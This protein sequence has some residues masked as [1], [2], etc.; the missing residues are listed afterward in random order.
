MLYS[1]TSAQKGRCQDQQPPQ[2]PS[3]PKRQCYINTTQSAGRQPGQ[4]QP[5]KDER[6]GQRRIQR[7]VDVNG[8]D[9]IEKRRKASGREHHRLSWTGRARHLNSFSLLPYWHYLTAYLTFSNYPTLQQY[10]V[11]GVLC[12][13][14][15]SSQHYR[16]ENGEDRGQTRRAFRGKADAL[17]RQ[18]S[19]MAQGDCDCPLLARCYAKDG[20]CCTIST[21]LG[22]SRPA[23]GSAEGGVEEEPV[24]IASSIQFS[25]AKRWWRKQTV[26]VVLYMHTLRD[27]FC[28]V[29]SD[30]RL[31][32]HQ[33]ATGKEG[34]SMLYSMRY[35]VTR[36][37]K[38]S[39]M[40][41]LQ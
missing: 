2:E 26:F 6:E 23:D 11:R 38:R 14:A 13:A 16:T 9:G 18:E 31:P 39:P 37:S 1:R 41:Q 19:P 4:D 27:S 3:S 15:T 7:I 8:R 21:V 32:D 5:S 22:S 10:E 36:L 17:A 34:V 30:L 29:D 25:M 33:P 12:T 40:Q 20:C 35:S 28:R 24:G